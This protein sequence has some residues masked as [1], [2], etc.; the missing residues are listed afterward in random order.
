MYLVVTTV[1][2]QS[3]IWSNH[4]ECG[5]YEQAK[6]GRLGF[7]LSTLSKYIHMRRGVCERGL[8]S[9]LLKIN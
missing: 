3:K 8:H 1:A 2:Y 5:N 6:P 7:I 9:K 4:I